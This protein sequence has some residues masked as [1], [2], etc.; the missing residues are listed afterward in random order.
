MGKSKKVNSR[1]VGLIIAMILGKHFL[2][3]EDLHY[4][5]WTEDMELKTGNFPLAQDKHSKLITDN[6]PDG[7][8]RVLDV[9]CGAGVLA[10]KLIALGYHVDCVSPSPLLSEQ[11]RKNIGPGSTIFES[12]FEAMDT[13]GLL[14]SYDMVLF[15]E[16]FQYVNLAASFPLI[17]KLL[18]KNGH[19]MICD[20][21]RKEVEGKSALGGGHRLT[22]FDAALSELPLKKL[23]DIDITKETAP[24][25]DIVNGFLMNVGLPVR[26]LIDYYMVNNYPRIT[27]LLKWKYRKKLDKLDSKYT[28]GERNGENFIKFKSYRLFLFQK[29]S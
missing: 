14:G 26:D 8:K 9:G 28:A 25:M 22:R 1:E 24:N 27:K 5:L 20:F 6:I 10:K 2:G 12:T 15:S 11:V 23:T 13:E 19:L 29:T 16:S 17:M 4:G 3:T 18:K 21:F 7:V